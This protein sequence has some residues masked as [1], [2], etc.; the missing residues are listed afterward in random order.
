[1]FDC[2]YKIFQLVKALKSDSVIFLYLKQNTIQKFE[3]NNICQL[4]TKNNI[5][6]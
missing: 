1:M 4:I 2:K 5:L 6:N 3:K